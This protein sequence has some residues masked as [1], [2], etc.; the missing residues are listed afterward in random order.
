MF[1]PMIK[2]RLKGI[3]FFS[4]ILFLFSFAINSEQN[5]YGITINKTIKKIGNN[6]YQVEIDVYNG[7]LVNGIAKYEAKLPVSADFVKE[8]SKDKTVN[9]K[10]ENRKIKIIWMY[11]RNN[12]TY[13]TVFQLKSN[14]SMQKLKMTGDFYGHREGKQFT[15][16]DT[17]SFL[18]K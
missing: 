6:L 18:L 1:G 3:L 4:G 9:F 12:N 16:K 10:V 11:L 17:T 8:V 13:S 7:D 14:R 5:Q 15:I 2:Y